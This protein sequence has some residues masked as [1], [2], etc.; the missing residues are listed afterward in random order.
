MN[1]IA[2][3]VQSPALPTPVDLALPG[4]VEVG[5]LLPI[6][7][8]TLKLEVQ[9]YSLRHRSRT[10]D[11]TETLCEARVL[12]GD[13]IALLPASDGPQESERRFLPSMGGTASW[14]DPLQVYL[15]S[16]PKEQTIT[17]YGVPSNV[18][19]IWSGPAGGTGRTTL[20]LSLAA[21]AARER[22]EDWVL[23]ALS[24]PA[25][26]AYLCLSRYPNVM[27]F[28]AGGK[29]KD[30]IQYARVTDADQPERSLR[31]RILLGPPQP[32]KAP[33]DREGLAALIETL[34]ST[35]PLVLFDLPPLV[36]GWN[37]WSID[38]LVQTD[39]LV[40]LIPP[41]VAGV[42]A[43]LEAMVVVERLA[44]AAS[45]HLVISRRS[46]GGMSRSQVSD[47]I[48]RIWGRAP[49]ILAD[50]P[51][52]HTLPA[53]FDEGGIPFLTPGPVQGGEAGWA[54]AVVAIANAVGI[55]PAPTWPAMVPY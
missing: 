50:I 51:H 28:L 13:T 34:R 9:R 53:L 36:P 20:A 46:P 26:S 33:A 27:R 49:D 18:V 8:Q 47:A 10:L 15:I 31:L 23:A 52:M 6:L 3:T 17:P 24:E 5:R 22:Q 40:L 41:T 12:N 29:L 11:E 54:E 35:F 16:R 25:V 4:D 55:I 42:S 14:D 7:V 45:L 19:S 37:P 30:A 44:L 48:R 38:P 43:A 21:L 32:S 1:Q 2:V 39:N